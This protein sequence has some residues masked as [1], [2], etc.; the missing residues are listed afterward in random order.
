MRYTVMR[1]APR[2]APHVECLWRL[3]GDGRGLPPETIVPDGCMEIVVHR[4]DRFERL[5]AG[6]GLQARAF[7]VGQ[8]MAPVVVRP[9]RVVETWGIRF[10]PGGAAAFFDVPMAELA[11]RLV[12]LDDCAAPGELVA[13]HAFQEAGTPSARRRCLEAWLLGRLERRAVDPLPALAARA[14][15]RARGRVRL[16]D[17]SANLGMGQRQLERRFLKGVGL[18][19]RAL[20]RLVR[21]QQVFRLVHERPGT[22][23]AWAEL[24]CDAGYYDQA[25]LLRDFRELAGTTPPRFLAE[26]GDFSRAL[27]SPGRLDDLFA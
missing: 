17:L 4:G 24:A 14:I 20:A 7:L 2:L 25:H 5:G 16:D 23:G 22:A 10:R 12:D 6:G 1:P 26:Q 13:L 11:G 8:M 3:E 19:P 15:V 18:P 21:F 27:T 9:G